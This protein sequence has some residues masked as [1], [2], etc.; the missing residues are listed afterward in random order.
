MGAWMENEWMEEWINQ[1]TIERN[2]TKE[3]MNEGMGWWINRWVHERG[4]LLQYTYFETWN[5]NPRTTKMQEILV[6]QLT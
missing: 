2:K 5:L 6:Q 3:W 4:E 1:Q